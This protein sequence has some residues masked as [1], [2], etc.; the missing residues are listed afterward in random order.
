VA[1]NRDSTLRKAEKLLKQGRL[2]AAIAEYAQV[3]KNQPKDWNTTNTLGDLYVRAGQVD[4]ISPP[5]A[6]IRKPPRSTRR[7]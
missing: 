6:F 5:K 7:S 4:N 1:F 3:V 2:D